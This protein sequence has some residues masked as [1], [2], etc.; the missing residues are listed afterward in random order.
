[1]TEPIDL[2]TFRGLE[3]AAGKEFVADLARTFLEEGPRMIGQLMGAMAEG[4]ADKFRRLA[5]SLK[6]NSLTFGALELGRRARELELAGL[7]KAVSGDAKALADLAEE[8]R[9]V[10]DALGEMVGA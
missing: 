10:A 6:S 5:H 2:E 9:R 7:E 3:E 1:M 8:Y 4:N